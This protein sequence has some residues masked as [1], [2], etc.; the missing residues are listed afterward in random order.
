M[1]VS[2]HRPFLPGT[3]LESTVI[4]LQP[5][6]CSTFRITYDVPSIAVFCSESI[7]CFPGTAS[8]FFLKLLVPI[9]VAPIIIGIIV[10]III[11][12]ILTPWSRV[13]L[14]KLTRSAASQEIPRIFGTRRFLTVLTSARHLSLSWADSIHSPQPPPTSWRSIIILSSHLI[15][16][17]III[18]VERRVATQL[19][20]R[21]R[22]LSVIFVVETRT[23]SFSVLSRSSGLC[24]ITGNDRILQRIV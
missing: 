1:D 7:E 13:L 8:K 20:F 11:I 4:R 17:I 12:I 15:I 14:E 23:Y 19:L 24:E 21:S 9:P 6:H 3:S 10:I 18:V 2:C 5:S 22:Y 16:I